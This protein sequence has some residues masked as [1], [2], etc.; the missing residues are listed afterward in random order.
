VAVPKKRV[1]GERRDEEEK[2]E[3]REAEEIHDSHVLRRKSHHTAI[4]AK[5]KLGKGEAGARL[6][7]DSA[8]NDSQCQL[9]RKHFVN[10]YRLRKANTGGVWGG[11]KKTVDREILGKNL[12]HQESPLFCKG[13]GTTAKECEN[14]AVRSSRKEKRGPSGREKRE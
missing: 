3:N 7:P 12:M 6:A 9:S 14:A 8:P 4:C 2:A 13:P 11:P 10:G 5:I 1:A